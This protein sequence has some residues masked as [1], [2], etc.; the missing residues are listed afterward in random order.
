[1]KLYCAPDTISVAVAIAL[2][3]LGM[4]YE[5]VR[6]N[7]ARG[8]QNA[9]TFL[10]VNPKGRVPALVT[11]RGTLTETGA[12]LEYIA[13]LSRPGTFVPE[14]PWE[15]AQM[16]SAMYYLAATFHV[17]HAH[18]PRGSR[19]A[20][21]DD[22]LADM[23]ARVP[24]TMA[25]SCAFIEGSFALAPYVTG[26]RMTLADPCLFVMCTWLAGD[27]VDIRAYPRLAA[28]FAVI[29]ARPSVA[30][31]REAGLIG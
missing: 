18:G 28:H 29:G 9:A 31:L 21:S 20:D 24:R 23:R 6:L 25:E 14:D 8:D 15:A 4:A 11:E 19:W 13:A 22:S 7:F 17:N 5:A 10:A 12:I 26:S 30:R 16:R 2:E 3:E 1:M 27:G